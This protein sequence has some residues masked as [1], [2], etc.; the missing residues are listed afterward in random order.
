MPAVMWSEA[1]ESKT[2]ADNLRRFGKERGMANWNQ[3]AVKFGEWARDKP[4]V[5]PIS[6]NTLRNLA[7]RETAP[8]ASKLLHLA[9]FLEVPLY[10]LFIEDCPTPPELVMT[11]NALVAAFV[12]GDNN[13]REAIHHMLSA[14]TS[15]GRPRLAAL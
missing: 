13:T 2:L 10:T 1:P 5:E 14:F 3:M 7:K 12:N 4:F 8:Q 9:N 6:V 11:L 15:A